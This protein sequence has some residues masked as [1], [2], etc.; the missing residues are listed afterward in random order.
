MDRA[1]DGGHNPAAAVP[2]EV[3][4]LFRH[5]NGDPASM[6]IEANS[7]PLSR[8]STAREFWIR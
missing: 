1:A 2:I 8:L 6:Y 5:P 7:A 4:V 3:G